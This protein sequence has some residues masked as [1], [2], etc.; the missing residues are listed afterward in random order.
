MEFLTTYGWALVVI[1]IAAGALS[2]F[3]VF[4]VG[5]YIPSKCEFT[6][7][8]ECADYGITSVDSVIHFKLINNYEKNI[9]L[10]FVNA[11]LGT[12][13]I[14]CNTSTQDITPDEPLLFTPSQIHEIH[15]DSIPPMSSGQKIDARVAVQFKRQGGARSYT[16]RG[17]IYTRA[18]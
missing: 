3:G 12:E 13:L 17:K 4:N 6:P 15:C 11:T 9:E 14:P 2:Y 8:L 7:E 16:L 10:E 5:S 18:S 1:L